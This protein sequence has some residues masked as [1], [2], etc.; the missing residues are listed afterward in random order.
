MNVYLNEYNI[1]MEKSAYLPIATGLLRAYAETQESIRSNYVFKPFFYHIEGL[2]EI[3]Q[4]YDDPGIAAFSVSMWN[5]SLSLQVAKEVKERWPNCLIVVGGPQV[6]QQAEDYF[7]QHPFIDVSVRAEGEEAFTKILLRNLES[8]NFEG[9]AGLS[10]RHGGNCTRNVVESHQPKDMDMYPSPYLEG[11]FDG[12][13][14]SSSL[15]LQATIETNRGCPFPCAFCYWGQGGLSRKYRFHGIDRVRLEIEWAAKNK[16]KYLFNA[17]SNFGMHKRDEEIAQILVDTKTRYGY[18]EKFRTC[19]G[20]NADER[21]YSIAQKLH[22]ADMEKGITLAL[23]S[24]DPTVLKNINR[25]N[26]K[27]SAYKNLQVKFNEAN[28]PVY[29]ELILGLPGETVQTWK[30][31][32]ETLLQAGLQNQ[33]FVYLCQVFP[34]TELY[35]P[36]YQA[37]FGI[38]THRIELN[39]IHGAIRTPDLTTE[40]ED[41]IV[42]T[43]SMTLEDWKTMVLLSWWTMTLHSLK[44]GFFVLLYLNKLAGRPF[45][46][47]LEKVST[48][49]SGLI[50]QHTRE[51]K[52]RIEELLQG[53]GRG[54]FVPGY[55][56]IY[57]DEEEAAFLR[58]SENR[59]AFYREFYIFLVRSFPDLDCRQIQEVIQYQE[60]RIPSFGDTP[61]KVYQF[62][63]NLPEYFEK[64]LT[65]QP[66]PLEKRPQTMTVYTKQFDDRARFARE[67]IM[68]G[69][70]SG[71]MMNKVE[72]MNEGILCNN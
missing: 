21:I 66:V 17:D 7:L 36:E 68:W 52:T 71:T 6:P 5:E 12:I 57:W 3:L 39:E 51:F 69:R 47:L 40:Y 32:I 1:K 67:T 72:W 42:T 14:D 44:T 45:A 25:Q 41:I 62:Q 22:A 58:I 27:M 53:K 26:I 24:N 46:E 37:R 64:I 19:F 2:R 9:I 38:K 61:V 20:K 31:G 54:R 48:Y 43:D 29:S 8:R 59:E 4:R 60:S 35:N 63:Y 30:D 11:L 65:S 50:G 15:E 28:V 23:Q 70:K 10:W 49:D 55:S 34:N 33:L 18:P 13:M 56:P 16:I